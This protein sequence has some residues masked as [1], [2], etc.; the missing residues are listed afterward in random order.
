MKN[1]KKI[2]LIFRIIVSVITL[3]SFFL[4]IIKISYYQVSTYNFARTLIK[5]YYISGFQ[6]LSKFREMNINFVYIFV[7]LMSVYLIICNLLLFKKNRRKLDDFV[8]ILYFSIALGLWTLM[9]TT[10][11]VNGYNTYNTSTNTAFVQI[12]G[13]EIPGYDSRLYTVSSLISLT[14][15]SILLGFLNI[16]AYF[17]KVYKMVFGN[18]MNPIDEGYIHITNGEGKDI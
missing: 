11:F 8:S 1:E 5:D 3:S 17:W 16:F 4:P 18:T 2:F 13:F 6:L 14:L 9:I 12:S 10:A 15:I 7:L